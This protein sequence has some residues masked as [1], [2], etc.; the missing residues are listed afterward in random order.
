MRGVSFG[1]NSEVVQ[2]KLVAKRDVHFTVKD[3]TVRVEKWRWQN[4]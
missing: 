3:L 1:F 2:N 4:M